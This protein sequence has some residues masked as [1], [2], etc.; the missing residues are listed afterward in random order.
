MVSMMNTIVHNDPQRH[1]RFI[2]G[3]RNGR[4]HAMGA[5]IRKLAEDHDNIHVHIRYSQPD[6]D[7]VEGR[8]YDSPG[9]VDI[10]LLKQVLPLDQYSYFICGPTPFMMSLY[11]G[12]RSLGVPETHIHYEFF[13][14]AA[15]RKDESEPVRQSRLS[16]SDAEFA[17][18]KQ[19]TFARSGVTVGWDPACESILDLAERRGL[20][21]DCDCR[22]GSCHTCMCELTE[23]EVEYLFEP[24]DDP[25]PGCLL[26][27]CSKPKTDLVIEA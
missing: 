19:I 2:H 12:L 10:A 4:E 23:G 20:N 8:D 6:S 11:R 5:H 13:G 27:C 1:V 15:A 3:A 7:D 16:A 17:E 18:E 9:H 24:P 21:L 22:S 14:P 25:E 26:I